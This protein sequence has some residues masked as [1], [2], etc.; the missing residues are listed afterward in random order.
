MLPGVLGLCKQL[1]TGSLDTL[2]ADNCSLGPIVGGGFAESHA[3]W[4]WAF[5]INLCVAAAC[6]PVYFFLLPSHQPKPVTPIMQR[7]K[8]L[9]FLGTNLFIGASV[10][11][12]MAIAFGGS[13][14]SWKS[15]Q[16]IGLFACSGI[17]WLLLGAQQCSRFLTTN[18]G[19]IF[20]VDFLGSVD[21]CI[22]FA[23]T[24][25]CIACIF[26]PVYFIPL[27]FQFVRGDSALKAGVRLLPFVFAAVLGAMING[28]VMERYGLYMLWF[29]AG[30]LL[31][32][33]GG[34]LLQEIDLDT[35]VAKI[36]GYSVVA[37]IGS[38]FFVQAPFSVAQAKVD[39]SLVP[40]VTA[41]ISCGQISGITLSLAIASSVFVN[42]ASH[43]IAQILPTAP[44]SDIQAT[45]AGA[46]AAFFKSQ[47]DGDQQKIL[48]A[49]VST[50]AHVYIM[51]IVGGVLAVILSVFM[52]RER[53]FIEPA[54]MGA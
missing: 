36:Y 26:I 40:A 53:L 41:F 29:L 45:I 38:G 35:S 34:A 48:E 19:Q 30:G 39:A 33:A 7:I 1:H 54:V 50:M 17:L 43:K 28:A 9:D 5:Y 6:A 21:M 47:N 25:I 14:Y 51:V 2:E 18:G 23:Q 3:T 22:L 20:P 13:I 52:K 4:R 42:E 37:A 46:G 32:T 12:V 31:V 27:F 11:L 44:S 8:S 49:I 15:G 16:I 10:A 24:G